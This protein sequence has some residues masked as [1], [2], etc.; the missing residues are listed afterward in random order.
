MRYVFPLSESASRSP[1]DGRENEKSWLFDSLAYNLSREPGRG[2]DF[3]T[4][5]ARNPLKRLD[6]QK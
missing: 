5:I 2:N 3:L 4:Y 6:P 1:L